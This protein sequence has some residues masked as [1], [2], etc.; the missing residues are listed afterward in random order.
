MSIGSH[1]KGAVYRT[2][3]V[4]AFRIE[5][6]LQLCSSAIV[7]FTIAH[8]ISVNICLSFFP[9]YF[10]SANSLHGFLFPPQFERKVNA[11]FCTEILASLVCLDLSRS[12]LSAHIYIHTVW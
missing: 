10:S 4:F 11:Q 8:G 12:A 6:C 2:L 3:E 1:L 5:H 9:H 7:V